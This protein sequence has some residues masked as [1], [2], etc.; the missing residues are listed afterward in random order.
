M[1]K[2]CV[3][4]ILSSIFHT[5][6][7]CWLG[8]LTWKN[9]S[10]TQSFVNKFHRSFLSDNKGKKCEIGIHIICI[11]YLNHN[12]KQKDSW[13]L[14]I[15]NCLAYRYDFHPHTA[16]VPWN[17]NAIGQDS[18]EYMST[19]PWVGVKTPFTLELTNM[20]RVW[21]LTIQYWLYWCPSLPHGCVI[22]SHCFTWV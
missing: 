7:R 21:I 1:W 19:C 9:D 6:T 15:I 18:Y 22:T 5:F 17:I 20:N 16:Y 4:E 11:I 2:N 14:F 13:E 10:N 3:C 8:K 12:D